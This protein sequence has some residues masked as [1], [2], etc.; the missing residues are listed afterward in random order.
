MADEQHPPEER[1][2]VYDP[3]TADG[4]P[5]RGR[6]GF[7]AGVGVAVIIHL[8]IGAYVWKAKFEPKYTEFS[9]EAVKVALLKQAKAPPP[10]GAAAASHSATSAAADPASAE[11]AAAAAATTSATTR[12]CGHQPAVVA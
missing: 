5:R 8:A 10:P 9:D 2:H 1:H 6:R 11:G 4:R 12:G 3:L 7:L